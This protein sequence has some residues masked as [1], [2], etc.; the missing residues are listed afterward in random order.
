MGPASAP[1]P[2]PPLPAVCGVDAG[3]GA[4]TARAGREGGMA[5]GEVCRRCGAAYDARH[6][7]RVWMG[8]WSSPADQKATPDLAWGP[9]RLCWKCLGELGDALEGWGFMVSRPLLQPPRPKP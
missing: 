9:V 4:G 2:P 3:G 8:L 5:G 7:K 1:V 6:T